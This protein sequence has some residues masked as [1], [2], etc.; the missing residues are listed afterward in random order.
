MSRPFIFIAASI[1]VVCF[2]TN[3][4]F[5]QDKPEVVTP[6]Q[7]RQHSRAFME[8][9]FSDAKKHERGIML[10]AI[11]SKAVAVMLTKQDM[12]L[13]GTDDKYRGKLMTA[14]LAGNIGS[15]LRT[16]VK[17]NDRYAGMLHLLQMHRVIQKKDAKY[18][19][20]ALE[21]LVKLHKAGKLLAHVVALEKKSPTDLKKLGIKP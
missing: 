7:F 2:A 8:A 17:R 10:A 13:F 14:Y 19:N 12:P 3:Q 6:K 9:P 4:S 1:V 5:A 18:K 21:E 15:Q 11:Q 20:A 16:G